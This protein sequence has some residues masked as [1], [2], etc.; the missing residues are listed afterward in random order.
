LKLQEG[1]KKAS[2]DVQDE[3]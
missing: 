1:I 3:E 2:I